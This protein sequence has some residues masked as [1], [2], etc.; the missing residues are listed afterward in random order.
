MRRDK[1]AQVPVVADRTKRDGGRIDRRSQ[2]QRG[3]RNR[4]LERENGYLDGEEDRR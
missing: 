1:D 4:E 3:E 2:R